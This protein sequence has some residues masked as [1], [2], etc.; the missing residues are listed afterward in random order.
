MGRKIIEEAGGREAYDKK[1][2]ERM[3]HAPII[4][5]KEQAALV[6]ED[7]RALIHERVRSYGLSAARKLREQ[8]RVPSLRHSI[9]T[10]DRADP[11]A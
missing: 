7:W 1:A 8:E 6:F 10:T 11:D 4:E 9:S 2:R 3:L 5:A